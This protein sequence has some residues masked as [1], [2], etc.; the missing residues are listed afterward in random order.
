MAHMTM[1]PSRT[2]EDFQVGLREGHEYAPV[3]WEDIQPP[4]L[5]MLIGP[6]GPGLLE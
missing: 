6:V 2:M 4:G 1:S 5:R 3:P